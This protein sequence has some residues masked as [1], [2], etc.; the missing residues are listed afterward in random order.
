MEGSV[1]DRVLKQAELAAA[2]EP[3]PQTPVDAIESVL[4]GD[5]DA[6]AKRE[7]RRQ[8]RKTRPHGRAR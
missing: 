7:R 1:G 8:R 3:T 5:D 6:E 2:A 4:D